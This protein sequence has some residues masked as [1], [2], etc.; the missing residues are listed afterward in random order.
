M[1]RNGVGIS[2]VV[3]THNRVHLLRQCVENTLRRTS[4]ATKEILI[5]NNASS[6]GTRAYLD[7]LVD[8]RF[9]VIHHHTNIG[10]NAYALAFQLTS[11]EY[12]VELDDDVIEAPME[13][14]KALLDAFLVLP[15]IGFLAAN[16]EDDDHDTG[17]RTMRERAHLYTRVQV[18]GVDLLKGPTGG[19][20]TMTSRE[21]HDRVGGFPQQKGSVF[22]L[23]DAAYVA[24]IAKLGYEAAFV[25]NLR[26]HH[27]G[28]P[29]YAQDSPEKRAYWETYHKT[30]LRKN[31]IKRMLLSVP[32][33]GR[34]NAR[35]RWFQPPS[36]SSPANAA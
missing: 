11:A 20:C 4:P 33:V 8:P 6:D 18:N 10:Q 15:G 32:F 9:R 17:A 27:A 13:W 7:S 19:A 34:L 5:W 25:E 23:E 22:W 14:D 1:N 26:V 12:L 29:Y 3:L 24:S 2:I 21:L 35:F 36:T 31:A 30:A 16:L 28:G